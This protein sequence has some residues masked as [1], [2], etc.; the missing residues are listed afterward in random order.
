MAI[1]SWPSGVEHRPSPDQWSSKLFR[2]PLATD[3]EGG[4][5]RFRRRP[6]DGVGTVKWGQVL[7]P[8]AMAVLRPF[9]VTTLRNCTSRFTMSVTLDGATYESRVVQI[10]PRSLQV[11]SARGGHTQVSFEM[12]VYPSAVTE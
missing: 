5:T 1:P 3:M 6:G 4:N 12:A 2:D 9:L 7:S 11:T 8:A 10:D